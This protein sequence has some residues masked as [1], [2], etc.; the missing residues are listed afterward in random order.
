V[1]LAAALA[2]GIALGA[3][4]IWFVQTLEDNVAGQAASTASVNLLN[5][6][7]EVEAVGS[8]DKIDTN[9]LPQGPLFEIVDRDGTP[10]AGCPRLSQDTTPYLA[11]PKNML[12]SG[13]Y[14]QP[15]RTAV[16]TFPPLPD[17]TT[18]TRIVDLACGGW[19]GQTW[20]VRIEG[21]P[22]LDGRY[23]LYA[24]ATY[25]EAGQD[26]VDNVRRQLF[27]GVPLVALLVA[28]VAWFAVRGSLRPVAAIRAEVAKLSA[29]DLGKRVPVPNTG[30][31][32]TDLATTMNAMLHRISE[33]VDR[34]RQF[35]GDASHELKTPL[36]S[37]RTQLEV[38]FAHPDVIDWR[39]ATGN[40][41]LDL[42]RMQDLIADLLLLTKLDDQVPARTDR[43]EL[44]ELAMECFRASSPSR[45]GASITLDSA[46]VWVV[47]DRAQ[48]ARLINNLLANAWRHAATNAAIS[49]GPDAPSQA[50]IT[51]YDD[52]PG[53][54]VA[55]RERVFDRFVRLDEARSVDSGGTGL[56][57]A[58]VRDIAHAHGGTVVLTDNN[59][60]AR[61]VVSL[62]S[63]DA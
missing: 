63:V 37:M 28:V 20:K 41:A 33:S 61:F 32:L 44:S 59:P 27:I 51:I 12:P 17:F 30:D 57:L 21:I 23:V 49:I 48:L 24:A 2:T 42:E 36:T 53:I 9:L 15:D 40:V 29:T 6:A 18:P 35:I 45:P 7:A 55:D 34:Q 16:V 56:G 26:V 1:A 39:Q 10:V 8:P 58:I 14:Y 13:A 46:P 4:A 38:L 54:P 60:G 62:P 19:A 43:V 47:G 3:G 52:G 31:E 11:P 50:V 25:A 5:L 22:L